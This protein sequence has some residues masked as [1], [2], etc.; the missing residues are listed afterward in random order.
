MNQPPP[1]YYDTSNNYYSTDP[2]YLHAELQNYLAREGD[3]VAQ[4]DNLTATLVIMEQREDLHMIQL[5]V[6]TERVMDVEAQAAQDRNLAATFQANCT[7]LHQ[8]LATMQDELSEWQQRCQEY[9]ERHSADQSALE[10]LK[11]RIKEKQLEAEDLAIAMEN[12]RLAE[13]RKGSSQS[14]R[15][16]MLSWMLSF[17]FPRKE[18]STEA[19]RDVRVFCVY[20]VSLGRNSVC[21]NVDNVFLLYRVRG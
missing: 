3:L 18:D 7:A 13:R 1:G 4:L 2:E 10:E 6:L 16:G 20:I 9:V 5:D 14:H 19:M 21:T 11:N 17:I 12:L 15:K 8:T